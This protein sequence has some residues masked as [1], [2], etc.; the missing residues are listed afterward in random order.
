MKVIDILNKINNGEEVP[1]KIRFNDIEFE[2]DKEQGEYSHE[3]DDGY[4]ETLLYDVLDTH[5]INNLL[6]AEVEVIEENKEIEELEILESDRKVMA[7]FV[8]KNREKINELVRA[9]NKINKEREE[10]KNEI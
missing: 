8:I 1:E 6:R 4:F 10:N 5:F 9:V 7:V 2:Y 3:T